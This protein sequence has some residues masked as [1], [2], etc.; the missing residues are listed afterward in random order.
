MNIKY[1]FYRIH[2][3]FV[4]FEL[5]FSFLCQVSSIDPVPEVTYIMETTWN[6]CGLT[7]SLDG[8]HH[9]REGAKDYFIIAVGSYGCCSPED[10]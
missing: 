3:A 4:P 1:S 5:V 10:S 2:F 8:V 9:G 6:G 7:S